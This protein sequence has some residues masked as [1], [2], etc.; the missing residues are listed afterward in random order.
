MGSSSDFIFKINTDGEGDTFTFPLYNGGTYNFVVDWGD[1][2]E[3]STVTAYNDEDR[4]HEY[5]TDDIFTITV[6]GTLTGFRFANSGDRL[7][8]IE[9]SNFGNFN[10]GNTGQTFYGCSNLIITAN[11]TMDLTGVTTMSRMF[12][13]CSSITTYPNMN[14][15]D[16]S[17][18]TNMEHV[19][20]GC[21]NFNQPLSQW[22][23]SSVTSMY[24]MFINCVA[25]NQDIG[26]WDTGKV[27][28]F[29]N[30]FYNTD[31]FNQD[32]GGWDIGSLTNATSMFHSGGL[33]QNNYD[34]LLIGWA[35]GPV[36]N[37]VTFSAG[38]TKFT[39]G[40]AAEAAKDHLV[41]E[42]SWAITDGGGI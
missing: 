35:D 41:S 1:G 25:F 37:G 12:Q 20:N 42:P 18:V 7:L 16:T 2:S 5:A 28:T 38:A 24:Q 14:Y 34:L 23:T 32:I 15:F 29:E 31:S 30:M 8:I 22:D 36:L 6:T 4:I 19:F 40:G 33:S 3:D 11:D 10:P 9:I 39:L 13:G 27:T 21:T 17:G 26:D